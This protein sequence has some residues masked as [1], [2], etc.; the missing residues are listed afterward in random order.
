MVWDVSLPTL[1][2]WYRSGEKKFPTFA[3]MA[4][5]LPEPISAQGPPSSNLMAEMDF[6]GK[7][8]YRTC[9]TTLLCDKRFPVHFP[10]FKNRLTGHILAQGPKFKNLFDSFLGNFVGFNLSPV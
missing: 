2:I 4:A 1:K 9:A 6:W 8:A 3:E 7:T 5:E 10:G